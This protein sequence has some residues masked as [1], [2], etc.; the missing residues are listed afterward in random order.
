MARIG[1]DFGTTNT[2]AVVHDR[3]MFSVVLHRAETGAGTIVQE[4]YPS[5]ILME[6]GA[7]Q[8]WFGLEA[9]RR[10]GQHG[11]GPGS[12]YFGSLKRE[13]RHYAEGGTVS[14]DAYSGKF[15][16]ADLLTSFLASLRDS[17]RASGAVA[18][19]EPLETVLT[20]PANANGAQRY[21][22]RQCFR[23]AGFE[24]LSTLNEPTASAIELADCLT[25]GRG[26]RETR[27][28]QAVA[29][30]DLGGGTFD[31]SVVWI[32]GDDFQVL[33]S[34]GIEDLGGDDFD[35]ILLEM[36]L[37]KLK[38]SP[39]A[40]IPLTRHALMRQARAQKETIFGGVVKTLFLNP[41]DF[42][43]QGLP[44]SIP[45]K[46]YYERLRPLIKPAIEM[47][48]S[49]IARAAECEPRVRQDEH[50]T[51]YL[52][53]GAA[54]LPLVS[55]MV[56]AAFKE[57]KVVL[58]DKPFTS[59]AMGAAIAAM[60]R[61]HYREIFA[62][63]FGLLRLRDSGR[64]E[65]FDVVFPAGTPI[66]GRGEPPLERASWYH[67]HHN[68]GHLRYLECTAIGPNGLPDG[69]VR[70]WSDVLFPYDPVIP[71]SARPPISMVAGT[72]QFSGQ[73]VCEVYRCDSDG[74]ITVELRRPA[75]DEIR[76]HEIFQD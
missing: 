20:W 28:P 59:V 14:M 24:V 26:R 57:C 6:N 16:I 55:E 58:T 39:D 31:A 60:D 63:H 25:A 5:A 47:L 51:L 12:L 7:D 30:F 42:G 38:L 35:R 64:T 65:V 46:A 10:F 19:D 75:T 22:T 13:L 71:L 44:V 27:E 3:G 48:R 74:V 53:G 29:V 37:D 32:D 21:I 4:T 41:M 68:I 1:V 17:I 15:A 76:T 61:V 36:F 45:V 56:A 23:D 34:S 49:V 9:D 62:R 2:V 73:T 18:A 70:A 40:V 8:R 67:P 50:L 33:A 54:K 43:L 69:S 11:P 66:P 52:V 72:E